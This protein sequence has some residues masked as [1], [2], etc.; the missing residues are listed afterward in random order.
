[1]ENLSQ[2]LSKSFSYNVLEPTAII[3][4]YKAYDKQLSRLYICC[5]F[6]YKSL[7]CIGE[8]VNN[9]FWKTSLVFCQSQNTLQVNHYDNSLSAYNKWFLGYMSGFY[10]EELL[11]CFPSSLKD[12]LLIWAFL[13]YCCYL[14]AQKVIVL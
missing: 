9:T 5:I 6:S 8:L 1:M 7:C 11:N 10:I 13:P 4:L 14:T 2:S 12:V 3:C